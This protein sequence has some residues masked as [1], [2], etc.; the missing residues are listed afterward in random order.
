[1][2]PSLQKPQTR[3]LDD[4]EARRAR[5]FGLR[6]VARAL[7]LRNFVELRR[8]HRRKRERAVAALGREGASRQTARPVQSEVTAI[9]TT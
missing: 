9:S 8:P 5:H 1:M 6:A 3:T 2:M 4:Y 7:G